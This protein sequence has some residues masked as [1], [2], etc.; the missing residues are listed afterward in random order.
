MALRPVVNKPRQAVNESQDDHEFAKS[1]RSH[2]NDEASRMALGRI[3]SGIQ[4]LGYEA[5]L[6]TAAGTKGWSVWS[7]VARGA[8]CAGRQC[9]SAASRLD[10]TE[11]Y[12][13]LREVHLPNVP[14]CTNDKMSARSNV[15]R[16]GDAYGCHKLEGVR[17]RLSS[18]QLSFQQSQRQRQ[19]SSPSQRQ[20]QRRSLR[21]PRTEQRRNRRRSSTGGGRTREAF[22]AAGL[23]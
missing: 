13:K 12:A 22:G 10:R 19:G 21:P 20:S 15:G 5:Y 16:N 9:Q 11:H 1:R 23:V 3:A 2:D 14:T 4:K 6:N 17:G 7:R 8:H 18:Q